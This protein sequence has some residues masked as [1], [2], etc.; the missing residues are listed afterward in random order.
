MDDSVS[1][2]DI[3]AVELVQLLL[4]AVVIVSLVFS[5]PLVPGV[6]LTQ[7]GE[8]TLDDGNATVS[9]VTIDTDAVR[10]TPGRFGTS[11]QYLRLPDARVDVTG[12]EGQPRLV[13][14]LEVP[15]LDLDLAETKLLSEP[16]QRVVRLP[17]RAFAPGRLSADRYQGRLTV[18][19][20]SFSTDYTVFNESVT[21]EVTR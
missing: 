19:V 18:R 6:S 4:V 20:Q 5:G 2:T 9:S 17:D 8:R 11:V 15:A 12:V 16:G 13:Y 1:P 14:R 10:I 3:G 21:I 7:A